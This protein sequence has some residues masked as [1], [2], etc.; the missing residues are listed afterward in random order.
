MTLAGLVH[1]GLWAF[2]AVP[3]ADVVGMVVVLT[4]LLVTLS[5]GT[6]A[7]SRGRPRPGKA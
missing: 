7:L 4:A 1:A 3:V 2:A 6:W 5:Y